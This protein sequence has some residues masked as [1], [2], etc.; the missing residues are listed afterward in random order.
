MTAA[1]RKGGRSPA[2]IRTLWAIAKSPELHL[3]EEDLRA[4]IYRETGKDSMKKLTQGEISTL[5]RILQNMK[6]GVNRDTKSKRTDEGG[7][8]RTE[9]QRHKIYALCDVLGWNNDN[10]RINAF[11][12]RMCGVERIE[13]LN[14]AQCNK[15]IEALKSMIERQKRKDAEDDRNGEPR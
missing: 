5:A 1:S 9:N 4:V 7:D 10:R 15:I 3:S 12:K 13:W 6:D 11:V 2:S 8:P 14:M